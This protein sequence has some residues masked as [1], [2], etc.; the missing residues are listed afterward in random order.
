MTRSEKRN[1]EYYVILQPR[2]RESSPIFMRG[3][4]RDEEDAMS[5]AFNSD[6]HKEVLDVI[7]VSNMEITEDT[8]R[9]YWSMYGTYEPNRI[10]EVQNF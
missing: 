3:Y 2:R 5:G 4:A 1:K 6:W 7:E 9:K 8:C 10:N